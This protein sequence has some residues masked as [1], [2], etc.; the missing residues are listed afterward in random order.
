LGHDYNYGDL[1]S[2]SCYRCLRVRKISAPPN[3]V[4]RFGKR[5]ALINGKKIWFDGEGAWSTKPLTEEEHEAVMAA[6]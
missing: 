6:R 3:Q 4:V 2:A 1:E 5:E